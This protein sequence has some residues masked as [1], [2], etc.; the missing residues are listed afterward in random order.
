MIGFAPPS[1]S[2]LVFFVPCFPFLDFLGFLCV[3]AFFSRDFRGSVGIKILVLCW[4]VCLCIFKKRKGRTGF[5]DAQTTWNQ[6]DIRALSRGPFTYFLDFQK[7][8]FD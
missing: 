6:A 2:F 5:T 3:F 7:P 1:L 4:G 8:Y